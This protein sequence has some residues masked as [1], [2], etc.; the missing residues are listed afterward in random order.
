MKSLKR[1]C[2]KKIIKAK[3][4]TL[5]SKDAGIESIL[6]LARGPNTSGADQ[7][8]DC[9]EDLSLTSKLKERKKNNWNVE[10]IKEILMEKRKK[11]N[12]KWFSSTL[13]YYMWF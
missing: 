9:V 11:I 1:N 13:L 3:K 4:L 5:T 7:W 8:R 2:K 12:E 10:R 6:N